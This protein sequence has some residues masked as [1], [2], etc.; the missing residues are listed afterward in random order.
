MK[1]LFLLFNI[2]FISSI[3]FAQISIEGEPKSFS[4]KNVAA[5]STAI[6]EVEE[7]DLTKE[8]E[9]NNNPENQYKVRRFGVIIPMGLNFFDKADMFEVDNGKLWLLKIKSNN[10]KALNIY[11]DDFYIP[12]GGELYIYN[13]DRTKIIGAF[14]SINNDDS[15][16]FATEMVEGEEIIVEY[17]Q[18]NDVE[19]NPSIKLNELGYAYRDFGYDITKSYEFRSSGSCN[20]NVNCPEGDNYRNAQR[21]VVR[22]LVR[23]NDNAS[24]WCS[25]SLVNNTA[26]DLAPYVL[27]AAHCV[28]DMAN[29]TYYNYFVFYFNYEA[30]SC[31]TGN[32]E[33]TPKT[34]T[35]ASFKAAGESSDFLLLRLKQNVPQNYNAYW[36]AW[37]NSTTASTS[38]VSIHHPA[39]DIKKI[40]TYNTALQ[41]ANLGAGLTHWK[42]KWI[43]TITN[44]GVTEGGSSGSPLFNSSSQIVGTL[45]GGT[46]GCN[47]AN[48]DKIDY[49]GKMSFSW[50]SNGTT[51]NKRLQPWLD[52]LNTGVTFF[53]GD[54]YNTYQ[55]SNPL[56][57]MSEDTYST[58]YPNP[59]KGNV[60]I[61]LTKQ[62]NPT[63]LE[64]YDESGR[65]VFRDVIPANTS[66]HVFNANS[67]N[68]GY[69][70]I[71]FISKDKTWT[72]KLIVQ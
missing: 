24:G 41:S 25:G 14:T 16:M 27:S 65:V 5:L 12:K 28:K 69:Y 57:E 52:P 50:A 11:S 32:I 49:Y 10:A 9:Y 60:N 53:R 39:G 48:A 22:I 2:L 47:V 58:I 62:L 38:G 61:T 44:H 34:M 21:G 70:L 72:N 15:R 43:L 64:V 42:V 18:P 67:L 40:S 8:I 35:G 3:S 37:N 54:D 68:T 59:A 56:I 13:Q 6:I 33:P 29:S 17:F 31:Q 63:N 36:N 26:R 71:K 7:P 66:E 20:V 30:A 51:D 23:M 19:E 55:T 45:T 46:S 1:R 4:N